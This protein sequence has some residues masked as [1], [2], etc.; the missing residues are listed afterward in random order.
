[1]IGGFWDSSKI[2]YAAELESKKFYVRN[3][4][5]FKINKQPILGQVGDLKKQLI[6]YLLL[7]WRWKKDLM[8]M[9]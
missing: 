3:C 8:L 2:A 5:D 9:W 6:Q 1:M 4:L 7:E